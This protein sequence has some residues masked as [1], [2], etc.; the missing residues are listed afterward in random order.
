MITSSGYS[1]IRGGL[2]VGNNLGFNQGGNRSDVEFLNSNIVFNTLY[3]N[4]DTDSG[5]GVISNLAEQQWNFNPDPVTGEDK[6]W[7]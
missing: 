5:N 3:D 6:P 4:G 1:H 7:N 2:K